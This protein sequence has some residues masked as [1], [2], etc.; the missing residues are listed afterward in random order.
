M[1]MVKQVII[2]NLLLS[3][4]GQ[5]GDGQKTLLFLHGW[6]SNKE[7]WNTVIQKLGNKEIGKLAMDLPGF[8]GS[9]QP[10]PNPPLR[11]GGE[12]RGFAVK[13]YANVV[14]EFI[15]KLELK[16]VV[17]VGHS[18]GGRV[19]IKLASKRPELISKLV[20]VDSAGFAMEAS[21]KK[22]AAMAAK[23]V[24]PIFKP[25]IMQGLRKKIYKKIGAEDYLATP[26]LQKT[27]VNI[28]NEDLSEDMKKIQVPTLMIY[29][30]H[31]KNTPVTYGELM[32]FLIPNSK[33]TII[34]NA[35]HFSFL[36]QPQEFVEALKSFIK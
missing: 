18:F 14:A 24:K 20:L 8:G 9:E 1:Y 25:Q 12:L 2:N 22:L 6:R 30:Q 10:L 21:K 5:K 23:I 34:P 7:I 33:L 16:N 26:E 13:D 3:Y 4:G 31:D 11:R 36:D 19:G 28:T 17:I 35:G 29:G 27:F 15:R 32:K